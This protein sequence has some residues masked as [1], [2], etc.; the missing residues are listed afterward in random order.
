LRRQRRLRHDRV[1]IGRTRLL[2]GGIHVIWLQPGPDLRKV[3]TDSS[4][5]ITKTMAAEARELFGQQQ[6]RLPPREGRELLSVKLADRLLL[7][8]QKLAELRRF[9]FRQSEI[10]HA[11]A[12][13]RIIAK[14]P[15]RRRMFQVALQP[16][17]GHAI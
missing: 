10:G 8:R 17:S 1:R 11:T 2:N 12:I 16:G 15:N 3:G 14:W 6:G 13:T 9:L 4:P 5:P 7:C